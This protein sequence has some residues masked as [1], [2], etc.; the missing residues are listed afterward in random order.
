MRRGAAVK[1]GEEIQKN[2]LRNLPPAILHVGSRC[3]QLSH[4]SFTQKLRPQ[5]VVFSYPEEG[6]VSSTAPSAVPPFL[7][8]LELS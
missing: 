6:L 1:V 4:S 8:G 2:N 3:C 5:E 7:M